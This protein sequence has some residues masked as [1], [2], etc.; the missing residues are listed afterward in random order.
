MEA[1]LQALRFLAKKPNDPNGVLLGELR[2]RDYLKSPAA[3]L[4]RLNAA[5]D[6]EVKASDGDKLFRVAI[7]RSSIAVSWRNSDACRANAPTFLACSASPAA[8]RY[9]L[10]SS[11]LHPELVA[12]QKID[13]RGLP[14]NKRKRGLGRRGR[15]R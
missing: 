9:S 15:E 4:Q 3:S 10:R 2:I 5:I 7:H 1:L 6:E 13:D 8:W 14:R 12:E 11:S